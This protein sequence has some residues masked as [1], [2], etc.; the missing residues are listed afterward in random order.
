[1]DIDKMHVVFRVLGQ[2]VGMQKIRAILPE[3]IDV[4]LNE[5]INEKIRTV[6][7]EN[8]NMAFR[9]RVS[10]H[11]NPISPINAIRTLYKTVPL[12][13]P[14]K[15]ADSDFYKV[16]MDIEKVMY[17]TSFNIDYVTK[18]T[19]GAR[20]IESD[21]LP[22]TLRDYCNKA[23]WDYPIVSMFSDDKDKEYVKLF[24]DSSTRVPQKLNVQY[25]QLPN[26][27]KWD[28]DVSKRV[29]CNLPESVHNEI[30]E[31]AVSKFFTSV[32]YTNRSTPQN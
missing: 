17:F 26:V 32:G 27:V 19:V 10:V 4:F 2:Q 29:D 6:V 3:S 14:A 8:T 9:D 30:V 25:I 24:N 12:S 5:V 1:M 22:D 16:M 23:S 28:A 13:V 11:K 31:L 15:G 21:F 18:K 7:L 20:F